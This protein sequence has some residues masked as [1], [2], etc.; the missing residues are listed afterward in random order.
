VRPTVPASSGRPGCRS[1][2]PRS[3]FHGAT[4]RTTRPISCSRFRRPSPACRAWPGW[5]SP[6]PSKA[7]RSMSA[8]CYRASSRSSTSPRSACR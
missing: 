7:S 6:V 3:A 2:S 1:R 4:S 8:C 5:N